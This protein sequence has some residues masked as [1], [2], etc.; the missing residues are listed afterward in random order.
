MLSNRLQC[1]AD[2]VI[3]CNTIADIGTDHG[4]IPIYTIKN[5]IAKNAIAAD[6]SK[7]SCNKAQLN[8]DLNGLND[9][10]NVRCGNGLE[11]IDGTEAVD[12]IIIAGMGGLMTISVLE[13]NKTAVNKTKQLVLQPQKDIDKVRRYIH[14][15]GFYI[16]SETMLKDKDKF[17]TIIDARKGSEEYTD[18]EYF[19]GKCNIKNKSSVLNE[20]AIIELNKIINVLK[21]ME[22][23]GKK[24][25]VDYV[26]LNKLKEMYEEVINCL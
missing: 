23:K 1:V 4:Y 2:K 11:V 6:I 5:K 3:N 19:F 18:L 25:T 13:S 7:G 21:S 10:I 16:K 24:D 15:I 9:V 20:Y 8:V 17:Y 12:S 26:R 14:S 22:I